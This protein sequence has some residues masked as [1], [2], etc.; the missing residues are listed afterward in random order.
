M[1]VLKIIKK[2]M[3]VWQFLSIVCPIVFFILNI[4]FPSAKLSTLIYMFIVVGIIGDYVFLNNWHDEGITW[5]RKSDKN[6]SKRL[7]RKPDDACLLVT[8]IKTLCVCLVYIFVDLDTLHV[9][10]IFAIILWII[11]IVG[12]ILLIGITHTSY[13]KVM[14]IIP[15]KK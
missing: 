12:I 11:N 10:T 15:K 1:Q 3:N 13:N 5:F 9:N 14:K 8:V 4:V 6:F 2:F 7:T